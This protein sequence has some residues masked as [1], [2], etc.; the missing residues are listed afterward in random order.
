M[1]GYICLIYRGQKFFLILHFQHNEKLIPFPI[2]YKA[3]ESLL[4]QY[5]CNSQDMS[6]LSNFIFDP[7]YSLYITQSLS[8]NTKVVLVLASIYQSLGSPPISFCSG[9]AKKFLNSLW[10]NSFLL[11]KNLPIDATIGF[12]FKYYLKERHLHVSFP[13]FRS[14]IFPK[15]KLIP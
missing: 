5:F 1:L 6:I 2:F 10:E 9:N 4:Q 7:I 15:I 8:C 14:L 12:C 11:N 13:S 3:A